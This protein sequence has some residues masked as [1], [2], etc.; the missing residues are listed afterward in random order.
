MGLLAQSQL[1]A[2]AATRAAQEGPAIVYDPR[3]TWNTIEIVREYGGRPVQSK[4]GHSFMKET[5]R[6]KDCIT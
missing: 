1:E 3:L 2:A 4:S 6:E 5:M